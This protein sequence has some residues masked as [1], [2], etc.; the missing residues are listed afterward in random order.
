MNIVGF[1]YGAHALIRNSEWSCFYYESVQV[2]LDT[3]HSSVIAKDKH[4]S[5]LL[6]PGLPLAIGPVCLCIDSCQESDD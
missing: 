6:G 1:H 2:P 5:M 4:Y 3:S